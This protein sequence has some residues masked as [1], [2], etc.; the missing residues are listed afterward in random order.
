M[1]GKPTDLA[2][3]A[4]LFAMA[5]LAFALTVAGCTS[6]SG[7]TNDA[8]VGPDGASLPTCTFGSDASRY[9]QCVFGP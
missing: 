8:G 2:T 9:G 5:I 3:A 6:S 4:V 7:A 1:N